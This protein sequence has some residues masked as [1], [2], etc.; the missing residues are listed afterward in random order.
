MTPLKT[1]TMLY[2]IGTQE[3]IHGVHVDWIIVDESEIDDHLIQGWS[4]TPA[5]AKLAADMEAEE[6]ARATKSSKKGSDLLAAG[7]R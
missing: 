1:A 5:D 4:L 7:E 6:A 3:R 2:R